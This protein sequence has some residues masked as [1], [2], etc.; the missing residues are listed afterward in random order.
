MKYRPGTFVQE[1]L[2]E[3]VQVDDDKGRKSQGLLRCKVFKL[4]TFLFL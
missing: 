2:F 4:F 1:F 3:E